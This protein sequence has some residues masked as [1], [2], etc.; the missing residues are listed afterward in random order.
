MHAF[1]R[2]AVMRAT[3]DNA[4]PDPVV[5]SLGFL[6]GDHD[7]YTKHRLAVA[8]VADAAGMR[9]V[10]ACVRDDACLDAQLR[11]EALRVALGR[12]YRALEHGGVATWA[13]EAVRCHLTVV[14]LGDE[15]GLQRVMSRDDLV[16][17]ASGCEELADAVAD[18]A[19]VR[20]L[21]LQRP[22]PDKAAHDDDA[23]RDEIQVVL[24]KDNDTVGRL[25]D[26]YRDTCAR[27]LLGLNPVL[28]ADGF[29]QRGKRLRVGT[30]VNVYAGGSTG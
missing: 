15:A 4:P 17:A 6:A 18:Y 3:P 13:R 19:A 1:V 28:V 12:I 26:R 11:D 29:G 14:D 5:A 2:C 27:D 22:W 8:A 9:E 10:A 23:G 7:M 16:R 20:E 21:C 24:A 25:C 30:K